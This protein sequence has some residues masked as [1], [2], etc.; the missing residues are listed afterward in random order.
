MIPVAVGAVAGLVAAFGVTRLITNFMFGVA[1]TD[2]ITF[3]TVPL[4]MASVALAA[5]Y[6][7]ARTATVVNPTEALRS[8]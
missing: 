1:P 4:L 7:P 3:F 5:A 2:P 6:L 8:E